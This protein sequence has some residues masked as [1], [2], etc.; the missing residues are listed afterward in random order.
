MDNSD[1]VSKASNQSKNI[2]RSVHDLKKV[3][4]LS[5]HLARAE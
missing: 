3:V 1:T 4:S 5:S 2:D